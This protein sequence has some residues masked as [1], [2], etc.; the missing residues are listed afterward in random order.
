MRFTEGERS[1]SGVERK[2]WAAAPRTFLAALRGVACVWNPSLE[3]H[4]SM[5]EE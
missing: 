1:R 3:G 5:E 2:P 4:F